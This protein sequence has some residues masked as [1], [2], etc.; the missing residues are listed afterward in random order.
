MNV[1]QTDEEFEIERKKQYARDAAK[2][3][4]LKNRAQKKTKDHEKYL[5]NREKIIDYQKEKYRVRQ[6]AAGITVKN[7]TIFVLEE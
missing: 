5:R 4:Y 1:K 2:K 6:E 3:Y 7:Y